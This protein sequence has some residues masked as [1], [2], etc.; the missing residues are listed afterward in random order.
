MLKGYNCARKEVKGKGA[1]IVRR[2]DRL[3]ELGGIRKER[4]VLDVGVAENS[5][6]KG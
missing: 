3:Q 2:V 5:V 4:Q 6:S 1:A